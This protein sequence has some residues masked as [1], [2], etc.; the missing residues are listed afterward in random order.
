VWKSVPASLNT[1]IDW[2]DRE[3]SQ[4]YIDVNWSDIWNLDSGLCDEVAQL[5]QRYG[6]HFEESRW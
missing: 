2:K 3:D 6:Y 1:R 5:A 4:Q